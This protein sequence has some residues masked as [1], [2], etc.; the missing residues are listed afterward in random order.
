MKNKRTAVTYILLIIIIAAA[1]IPLPYYITK[2]GGAHELDPIVHV[3]GGDENDTGTFMLTTIRMGPANIYSSIWA[4]F[5]EFE[6][7]LP[8]EDV[9]YPHESD[10]EYNVRQFHLMDTSQQNA[11][12]VAFDEAGKSYDWTYKGVYVLG[13]FPGMPAEEVLE[14]G[15]RITEIDGRELKESKEMTNYVQLKK[16]GETVTVTYNRDDQEKKAEISLKSF[17][18]LGGKSGLG[19]SLA[20]DRTLESDPEVTLEAEEIGGPSA[21][22]MFSLEIYDQLM[23]EDMA[24]GRRIAGTGTIE[25]DGTVGRIGGIEQKVV[26]ADR[27]GAEIFFAPDDELPDEMNGVPTNYE[28]AKKAAAE[29]KTDMDIVPVKTF[30]DAVHYLSSLTASK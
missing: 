20:D 13:V 11:I 4:Y 23:E 30:S 10:N 7:I 19:I 18:E 12:T 29:I 8:K 9:R 3:E 25:A 5:R 27:A 15:D 14:A 21:G 2:P 22:L 1:F 6:E 16:A 26:A 17:P 28:E 24:A